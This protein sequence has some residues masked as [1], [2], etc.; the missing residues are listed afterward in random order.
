MSEALRKEKGMEGCPG[1]AEQVA[2]A[3]GHRLLG[4]SEFKLSSLDFS[5]PNVMVFLGWKTVESIRWPNLK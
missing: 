3:S 2:G 1:G 5:C 4:A